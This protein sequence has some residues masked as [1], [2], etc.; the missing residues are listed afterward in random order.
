MSV[1]FCV[2]HQVYSRAA[3]VIVIAAA[4]PVHGGGVDRI[5]PL[6]EQL[7][8]VAAVHRDFAVAVKFAAHDAQVALCGSRAAL[9]CRRAR[10][11]R[12]SPPALPQATARALRRPI[13]T[14]VQRD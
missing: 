8:V 6:I 13:R 5:A 3:A 4:D 9:K 2:I 14:R 10:I 1:S 7:A 12:L 11:V